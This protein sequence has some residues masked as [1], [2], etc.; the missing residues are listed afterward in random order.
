VSRT[1]VDA[2]R[3]GR[4]VSCEV[5]YP[6]VTSGD[7]VPVAGA[8]GVTFPVVACG[9]GFL[10]P[11]EV[12]AYLREALVADGF[13]V[14]S[15]TTE[16]GFAP[17]HQAFGLDL[18]FVTR[19]L[20]A[21][22]ASAGSL[23]YQRVG[24]T[25]GLLGHSM[26]GGATFL[27]A[28]ADPGITAV[29]SLAAAETTPSAVA[30]ASG[31]ALPTLLFSGSVDCVAPPAQHQTLMYDALGGCRTHV[32]I[33]GGSHCQFA[34]SEPTCELGETLAF[35][36]APGIP[37]GQQH[38]AVT[39]LLV[40]WF[41]ATLEGD[42]VAWSTFQGRLASTPGITH[43]QDCPPSTLCGDC[44]QT[45]VVDITDALT[46]AQHGVG[47]ITLTGPALASCDPDASGGISI[48]DALLIAQ[49]AAGLPVTLACP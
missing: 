4:G 38:G 2:S 40:P 43:L 12:Y 25:A 41:H 17:D 26:G 6:A 35:C 18:A 30:A 22:G 23:F 10:M 16:G 39:T 28:A 15:P 31:L 3:G 49:F 21:E 11:Y 44:N 14:A 37:R 27:G 13:I 8:P 19:E 24:P 42:L 7:S 46:A 29:A 48:L 5:H 20:Q 36:P 34:A 9:H 32:T 47:L 33:T 45:G 1:Y